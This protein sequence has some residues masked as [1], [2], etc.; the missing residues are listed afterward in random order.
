MRGA[1]LA[2]VLLA[3]VGYGQ[4]LVPGRVPSSPHS[5]LIAYHLR[6]KAVLYDS[7]RRGEGVPLWREDQLGGQP[8]LTHPQAAWG[9][10]LHALF[11]LMPPER[12]AGPTLFLLILVAALGYLAL[13][14]AL[15]LGLPARVFAS[16]AGLFQAKLI[17]ATYA[18]WLG[19]LPS[20]AL[21]P[22]LF[23]ALLHARAAPGW[24][25]AVALG[26][27]GALMLH[28]GQLQLVY[29]AG[30]VAA[31][32]LAADVLRLRDRGAL[33]L[34]D[35]V[36]LR[37]TATMAAAGIGA[38]V[39]AAWLLIPLARDAPLLTR[40]H[41]SY[42]FFLGGHA[43]GLRH[44]ATLVRP[45]AL[46]SPVD[47]TYVGTEL[48]EDQLYFGLVPLAFA[49]A[50]VARRRPH[51]RLLA[52]SAALT[53]VLAFD[54]PLLRAVYAIVPGYA[55][56]RCPARIAFVTST[57]GIAL[58][59]IGFDALLQ[60]V[61][62]PRR[63]LVLGLAL[64]LVAGEGVLLSRR[65]LSTQPIAE[66]LPRSALAERLAGEPGRIAVVGLPPQSVWPVRPAPSLRQVGG[67][68]AYA[69]AHYR[70]YFERMRTGV[71]PIATEAGVWLQ[72]DSLVRADLAD[73]LDV[74]WIVAP[75]ADARFE[76]VATFDDE[77]TFQLYKGVARTRLVLMRN[78]NARPWRVV[79]GVLRVAEVWHPGWHA[80]VD[81]VAR[82]IERVDGALL[83][84]A[85]PP[86]ARRV[87]LRF[88]PY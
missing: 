59:A 49:V 25:A 51:A 44:L 88:S 4:L 3:L 58:G 66:A 83:G 6:A 15:G 45:E 79:D 48:W 41:V 24:R 20:I 76:T 2:V 78:H 37:I 46:G 13:A 71:A 62:A 57:L 43:L 67:F 1:A 29:Y 10:P 40:A 87:E 72:L 85:V 36:A 82:P 38:L 69:F 21:L 35:R 86:G 61:P 16:V 73:A 70:D 39:A 9:E 68:D 34:R 84:V 23:A 64:L 5:D 42:E 17:L 12:A 7:L 26:I 75:T 47:H 32:W 56:F 11:W 54:T 60:T 50:A 65:Y 31:A 8:G 14:A 74:Q 33:R 53:L 81:G 18:G 19:V 77:P 22:W 28:G 55:L 27:V 30:L 80:T 63:R 52:V